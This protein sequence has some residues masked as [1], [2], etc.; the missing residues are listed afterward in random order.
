MSDYSSE[1]KTYK[2]LYEKSY[3]LITDE[4]AKEILEKTGVNN[5]SPELIAATRRFA[6]RKLRTA[7]DQKIVECSLKIIKGS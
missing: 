3:H 4:Q 2:E 1:M 5:P 7:L 6:G